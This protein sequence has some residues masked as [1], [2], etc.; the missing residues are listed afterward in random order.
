MGKYTGCNVVES[1]QST[2]NKPPVEKRRSYAGFLIRL[3]VSVL[4][5]AF[6]ATVAYAPWD[7]LAPVREVVRDVFCYD[8]FGRIEFGGSPAIAHII[9]WLS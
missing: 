9:E 7:I 4:I 8:V 1:V 2:P 6:I 3:G 5:I